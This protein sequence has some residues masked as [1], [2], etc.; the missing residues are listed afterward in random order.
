MC[1]C[2]DQLAPNIIIIH[3]QPI[4]QK[5]RD[6]IVFPPAEIIKTDSITFILIVICNILRNIMHYIIH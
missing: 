6:C 4:G 1:L 5:S 2:I 3:N